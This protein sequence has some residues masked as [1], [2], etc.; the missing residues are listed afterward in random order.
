[1]ADPTVL[2]VE[3]EPAL[4]EALCATLSVAGF[5]VKSAPEGKAALVHLEK[6][7]HI[8][9]LLSDIQTQPLDSSTLLRRARTQ[10]PDLPVLFIVAHKYRSY[11][12]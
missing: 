3:H 1:M 12:Y 4:R 11:C 5:P 7:K 8:G 10:K 9:L 2:V 6:N